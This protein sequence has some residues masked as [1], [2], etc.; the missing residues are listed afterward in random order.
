M[1]GAQGEEMPLSIGQGHVLYTGG[2]KG[3]DE[4]ADELAN[5]FGMQVEVIVSPNHPRA[6]YV[7]PATVEVLVLANPHLPQAAQ[8]LCKNVPTHFYTLQLLQLNYQIAKKA[9]IIYDFGRLEKDAKRVQGEMGRPCNWLW[10]KANKSTCLSFQV[11][12]L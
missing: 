5:H 6:K 2:A 10:I 3:T 1:I 4:L 7:S 11:K 9:H 8:K 12:P